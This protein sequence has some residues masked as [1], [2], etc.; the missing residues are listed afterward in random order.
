MIQDRFSGVLHRN[1]VQRIPIDRSL[2]LY[3]LEDEAILFSECSRRL[4]GLDR[5]ATFLFLRLADGEPIES[6][7]TELGLDTAEIV[8]AHE[9]AELLAGRE[10]P[11]EEYRSE[12]YYPDEVPLGSTTCPSYRLMTT[13]FTFDCPDPSLY[14]SLSV[15]LRHLLLAEQVEIELAVSIVPDGTLWQLCFNGA[16]QGKALPA[17]KLL[18]AIHGRLR[19]IAYQRF[20][21][22]LAV[23]A[24]VVT[25]GRRTIVLPGLSGSGKSTLAATLLARGY[26]LFSDEVAL[27]DQ[28]GD[29]V[30]I[31]LGLCLK[32]GSW[33]LLKDHFPQLTAVPV[34]KR[35]DGLP[36]RFLE[37]GSIAFAGEGD[38][39]RATH[40]CFPRFLPDGPGCL[41]RLSPVNAMRRLTDSGYQVP[42]LTVES[43]DRIVDWMCGLSCFSLTYSSTEEA[44]RLLDS[45][46]DDHA[47]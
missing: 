46:L 14:E 9:L 21:Y 45:A 38:N 15:G 16:P 36:V 47:P 35:W 42:G 27:M 25:D 12:T 6:L 13:Y 24:A 32:E 26:R 7:S 44:L 8:A 41:E 28:D 23:H 22:L 2:F 10:P 43:A 4:F 19:I 33:P 18:P 34:H 17:D 3:L 31:P 40:L 11:A 5:S 30:P 29:L 37:S 39:R 20:P 1:F